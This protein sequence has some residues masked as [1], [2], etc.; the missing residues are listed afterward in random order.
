MRASVVRGGITRRMGRAPCGASFARSAPL[1]GEHCAS[2]R[3][4]HGFRP[5]L[6]REPAC[7]RAR[8][9][10]RLIHSPAPTP[11]AP[12]T[13]RPGSA[14]RRHP[15]R[16]GGRGRQRAPP[17]PDARR[18][19]RASRWPSP[20][21][22]SAAS[23]SRPLQAERLAN[24]ALALRLD[25]SVPVDGAGRHLR[26]RR[27]RRLRRER[28]RDGRGAGPGRRRA[29]GP[30]T[31]AATSPSRSAPL[32][33]VLAVAPAAARANATI[34]I[35]NAND[36]GRRLQRPD[37]GGPARLQ[38][39]NHRRRAA[40]RG[41]RVRRGAVGR[42]HRQP[43]GDLHPGRLH[44][45]HLHRHLGRARLGRR[46]APSSPTSRAPSSPATWYP[47]ALADKLAGE[48][49]D[50]TGA[51]IVAAFNSEVGKPGCLE[52]AAWY[53]GLDTNHGADRD[54]PGHRAAAR[55]RP[56][57]GLPELRQHHHGAMPLDQIDVYSLFY[58]DH[59]DGA[60][61]DS[62]LPD[63]RPA[64]RLG[65]PLP[66]RGLDRSAHP[67][68]RAR[69]RSTPG[70][71]TCSWRRAARARRRVAIGTALFGPAL[72]VRGVEGA[73]ALGPTPPAPRSAAPFANAAALRGRVVLVDRGTCT[74][75]TKTLNAQ[76]A[77]ARA[78]IVADNVAGGPP[79]GLG[80]ADPAH[81]HPGGAHRPARRHGPQGGAGGAAASRRGWPS[82]RAR[83]SARTSSRQ[84]FLN[85]T[86]P[87]QPGSSISHWDPL[88][89]PSQLME[90]A[91]NGDLTLEVTP[92][93]DL[94]ERALRDIGWFTDRNLDGVPDF[95]G[96]VIT[97]PRPARVA[98]PSPRRPRAPLREAPQ[99]A[100]R[101]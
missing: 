27:A 60:G 17:G 84:V 5:L 35:V 73:V 55:V 1:A 2:P 96:E 98:G 25:E 41:L 12:A 50:P 21:E 99:A 29:G 7:R 69:R 89:S 101:E 93:Q 9:P 78:V 67:P 56:R 54:Q 74:F 20:A 62:S 30:P 63:R 22:V 10:H 40:A 76:A 85:A 95:P 6:G 82:T 37:A 66:R 77:G 88:T 94:D 13:A 48:D 53:Y 79:P 59:L 32:L 34:T 15:G 11:Q 83:G 51:D 39:G 92:P 97:R 16:A 23:P 61:A 45:A 8:R 28:R 80:G 4:S 68:G 65:A 71:P 43:R 91:I 33:A 72:T 70:H 52:G 81:H 57:P 44:P 38:P 64:R 36:P 19:P 75:T 90:P 24:G 58:F 3:R 86:D 14:R 26:G 46:D 18:G 100:R 49:L 42:G 47:S 87:V 31:C